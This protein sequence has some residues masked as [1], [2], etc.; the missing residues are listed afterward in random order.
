MPEE[1]EDMRLDNAVDCL[2]WAMKCKLS[3]Q[4]EEGFYGWD[5]G[6]FV[7]AGSCRDRLMHH[8][9]R[10]LAG[11]WRQLVDVV[12]YLMFMHAYAI[13]TGKLPAEA[14]KEPGHANA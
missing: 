3:A 12:N 13:R 11:D 1:G 9:G 7:E 5:W 8:L 10:F 14:A 6:E 2:A 4:S